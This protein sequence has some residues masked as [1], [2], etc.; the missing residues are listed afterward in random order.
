[1][2][3]RVQASGLAVHGGMKDPG[4]FPTSGNPGAWELRSS[5]RAQT[6]GKI[7][8]IRGCFQRGEREAG[9]PGSE[10]SHQGDQSRRAS[11]CRLPPARGG[12]RE[13]VQSVGRGRERLGEPV[14]RGVPSSRGQNPSPTRP[15]GLGPWHSAQHPGSPSCI[16]PPSPAWPVGFIRPRLLLAP[17]PPPG[18]RAPAGA[19]LPPRGVGGAS[20]W[21]LSCK[22]GAGGRPAAPTASRQLRLPSDTCISHFRMFFLKCADEFAIHHLFRK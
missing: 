9:E 10:T 6:E 19:P 18:A 3:S 1:M 12:G 14:A 22:L 4:G 8:S 15:G 16:S 2:G 21:T 13:K 17:P 7:K 5:D 11:L 20:C